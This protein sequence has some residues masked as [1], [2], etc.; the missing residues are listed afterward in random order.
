MQ[1]SNKS[2]LLARKYL[3]MAERCLPSSI[4]HHIKSI[5]E[6]E[7]EKL[8]GEGLGGGAGHKVFSPQQILRL[9]FEFSFVIYFFWIIER[10]RSCGFHRIFTVAFDRLMIA[11][12]G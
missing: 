12:Q 8:H 2:I 7:K 11:L 10:K 5:V 9:T 4:N 6:K 3:S 1:T